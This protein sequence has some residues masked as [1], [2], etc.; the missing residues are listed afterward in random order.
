MSSPASDA[1]ASLQNRDYAK[2]LNLVRLSQ[3]GAF[4]VVLYNQPLIPLPMSH[5][6]AEAAGLLMLD[7]ALSPEV[8]DPL[9]YAHTL[10]PEERQARRVVCVRGFDNLLPPHEDGQPT[11]PE[12]WREMQ[13]QVARTLDL[14]R[15]WL[16]QMPHV[17]L[18]WATESALAILR[19]AAPNFMSQVRGVFDVRA[20]DDGGAHLAQRQGPHRSIDANSVPDAETLRR[21]W[22]LALEQLQAV[23]DKRDGLPAELVLRLLRLLIDAQRLGIQLN[24]QLDLTTLVNSLEADANTTMM[25]GNWLYERGEAKHALELYERALAKYR[26]TKQRGGEGAALGNLGNA[27]SDVGEVR[28]AIEYY[29]QALQIAREI[30]NRHGEGNHLGNLG[31]A[32]LALGEVRRA[33]EYYEQALLIAREIGDRRGEGNH[34][35]NLG[36]AYSALGEVRRAIEYY[37]QALLISREIGD[38]RGEG[39]DLGNLGLAYALLDDTKQ[40]LPLLNQSIQMHKSI[41]YVRGVGEA[42]MYRSIALVSQD[43]RQALAEFS[44]GKDICREADAADTIAE[45]SLW[46]AQALAKHGHPTEAQPYAQH[47][48]AYYENIGSAH[49]DAA[50]TLLAASPES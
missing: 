15:D 6:L 32:Y 44:K 1:P 17:F 41:Q 35:G 5:Q 14:R 10:S 18:V 46:F 12:R 31:N 8:H 24:E 49:A 22:A 19:E 23:Q 7:M 3:S 28:R 42:H 33:I 37:E 47:A 16:G 25:L 50:K 11:R 4:A 39:A 38:R 36:S 30:G 43:V 48:L 2:L 27:Y 21:E 9:A 29:E 40:A 26:S 13:L 45:A 34:L 20:I